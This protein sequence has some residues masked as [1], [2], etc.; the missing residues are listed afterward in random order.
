MASKRRLAEKSKKSAKSISGADYV[1]APHNQ[2]EIE[3]TSKKI[4]PHQN[5]R[6]QASAWK[7][8]INERRKQNTSKEKM[9]M[10]AENSH[11][12]RHQWHQK[13]SSKKINGEMAKSINRR[14]VNDKENVIINEK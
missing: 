7:W 11:Q 12:W 8:K 9:K 5:N 14:N 4:F 3:G 10:S 13:I 6:N 1:K 2:K